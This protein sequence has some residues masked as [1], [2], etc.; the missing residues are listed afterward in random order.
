MYSVSDR[1]LQTIAQGGRRKT[2]VDLYYGAGSSWVR[3]ENDIPV[4][5]GSIKCDSGSRSR[6]SGNITVGDP[7]LFPLIDNSSELNPYGTEMVVRTGFVYADNTEEL[8]PMGIFGIDDISGDEATGLFPEVAMFD[9]AQRVYDMSTHVADSGPQLFGGDY[10]SQALRTTVEGAAPGWADNHPLWTVTLQSG[11][12]DFLIPTGFYNGATDRWK[13]AEDLALSMGGEVYFD[14]DGMCQVRPPPIITD[15]SDAADSVW[16]CGVGEGTGVLMTAARIV[17]RSNTYNS[18]VMLGATGQEGKPQAFAA[19]YD[20]DTRSKTYYNGPFG[21]KTLRVSNAAIS[22]DSQA[23]AAAISKL[24]ST[25]GLSR[26][27]SFDALC[28]PALDPGD[29][30]TVGFLN[31]TFELHLVDSIDIDLLNGKMQIGTRST[32]YA[33]Q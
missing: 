1:F 32:Q 25:V 24:R 21:K 11:I 5:A 33:A 8:I 30:I 15:E 12:T 20:L 28:N 27:L 13:M 16:E 31:G 6:R 17:S 10:A 29:M 3:I 2:V 7:A 19:V 22:S 14:R 23:Y 4:V 26:T 9:R 18:V